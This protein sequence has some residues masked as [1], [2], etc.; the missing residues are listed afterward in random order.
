M[1]RAAAV[2]F[3]VLALTAPGFAVAADEGPVRYAEGK[4]L[5]APVVENKVAPVY[6]PEARAEGVQG[7]VSV[8]ATVTREGKVTD[9]K[10]SRNADPRLDA[11]ALDAVRQ[12]TFKPS[13]DK[14]GRPV[15]VVF[16]VTLRFALR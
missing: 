3:A 11:A 7:T 15:A 9:A 2:V 5:T 4:G 13:R 6:P 10:V 12:W 16:T 14:E 8:E 1:R